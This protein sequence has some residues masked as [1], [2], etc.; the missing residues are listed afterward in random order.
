MASLRMIASAGAGLFLAAGSVHAEVRTKLV[1]YI[2]GNTPLQAYVAWDDSQTGKRPA[3]FLIHRRDGMSDLTRANTEEF[4]RQGYVVF[5]ADIFGKTVRPKTVEEAEAQ[6]KIY[7]ND[8]ALMRAR[9][10]AGFDTMLKDPL[11]DASRVALI[12]YCFGGTAAFE[13]IDTGAPVIGT[14]A[15]HGSFRGFTPGA[16]KNIKG[17]V[18][19]LHGAEDTTA[20]LPEVWSVIDELRKAKIDWSMELYGGANHGFTTPNSPANKHADESY[21]VA[22]RAFFGDVLK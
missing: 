14:V 7:N 21:R 13:F 15:V 4:A 8:R 16:A 10:Q 9:T 17:R 2:Q 12:G 18:L 3:I 5:A 19:I 11:V 22:A 1:D 20:P 6:S